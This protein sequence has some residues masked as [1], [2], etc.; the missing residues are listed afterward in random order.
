[1]RIVDNFPHETEVRDPVFITLSDG[2]RLAARIWLP[3]DAE[4]NPVPAI[5][6]YLPYRRHD[7]TADRDALTHPYFAGNGY[8]SIRVD[9][10]GSGDSEGVLLGEYLMQ[11]QDD[12]LEIIDWITAQPWC[13]GTVGMIGIS[14]GGFN[15]LQV[16]ARRPPALK[17]IVSIC[18]TDDRYADDIHYMGGC[19]LNENAAWNAAMFSINTSPPD[20]DVVGNNWYDVWLA[21]LKGSGFWLQDWYEHQRRDDFY[22]HGSVCENYDDIEAA[23]YAVGGWADGYSNAVFRLLEGLSAPCKGLVGPWGHKYPHFAGPG[24]AIGFLQECLRWWDYW[25]KGQDTG[26][27]DEPK[28]RCWIEDP[29]PP[30]TWYDERPGRWVAD[31]S[32]PS[33][34]VSPVI[35]HLNEHELGE[36]VGASTVQTICSPATL[37]MMGGQWCP[38]GVSADMASDQREE[39]GGSL[40]FDTAPLDE[41]F[42]IL[43]APVVTLELSSDTPV[44]MTAVCLSEILPDG[45]VTRVTYGLLNLTHRD[46]HEHPEPLVPGQRYRVRVQLNDI[47]HRFEA[48]NRIRVAVSTNYWPIAWPSPEKTTLSIVTG[49]STLE[50]PRRTPHAG[51]AGLRPFEEPENAKP[52]DKTVVR[53]SAYDWTF[54]RDMNTGIVTQHQWFDEGCAIYN[55]HDGWMMGSTH[56]E[57]FSVDPNDPNS[58]RVELVWTELYERGAWQVTSKTRTVITSSKTHFRIVG[59]MEARQGDEVVHEQVWD[60][61]IPRDLV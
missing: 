49:E 11:E 1:M 51:D 28:L 18:S 42:D 12:A 15:G 60:R 5:L 10:R 32:W 16:A 44:A 19:M 22:K 54:T 2:V 61:E 24:P 21:R 59:E 23:V 50:L 48:G 17:A 57:T 40:V 29:V 45:A 36:T 7:G 25:L 39:A 46:S 9:M 30:R 35:Y 27:M 3:K 13:S 38:S 52:L 53:P 41:D 43:G 58:A 31:P 56:D 14:W 26:I 37:G 8:A 20:P 33:P 55:E 34:H 6:E 47:G 4:N